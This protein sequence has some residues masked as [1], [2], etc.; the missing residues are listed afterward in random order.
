MKTTVSYWRMPEPVW[1]RLSELIPHRECSPRGGRPPLDARHVA[2]GIY[3]VLRTGC[4]WKAVPRAVG[5]GSS[6]HRY[7]QDWTARGVFRRLWKQGLSEYDRRRGIVW[8]WQTLDTAMNKAP[9]G[10]EKNREK[11]HR[12]WQTRR[13]TFGAHRC[14]WRRAGIGDRSGQPA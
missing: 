3:F 10:G 14:T 2:D 5:S 6:L 4:P 13:Q 1:R 7:F 11:P 8:R 12:S 9:L